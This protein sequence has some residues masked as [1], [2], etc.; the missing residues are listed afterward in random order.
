MAK[1]PEEAK[2]YG[3]VAIGKEI[4]EAVQS[5]KKISVERGFDMALTPVSDGIGGYSGA[6]VM[7]KPF[8]LRPRIKTAKV[9]PSRG[10]PIP[11]SGAKPGYKIAT[12]SGASAVDDII[13]PGNVGNV[14]V[15]PA[16]TLCK[17]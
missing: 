12:G 4:E 15:G 13:P 6:K 17:L 8:G 1:G 10:F 16:K 5:G 14:N 2:P 7:S 9:P 3:Y 11:I